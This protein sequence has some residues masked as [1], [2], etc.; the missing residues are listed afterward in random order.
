MSRP[1]T[2]ENTKWGSNKGGGVEKGDGANRTIY[3]PAGRQL[4]MLKV[5]QGWVEG[6][7]SR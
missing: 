4:S 1:C 7:I 2:W 6:S 3:G 5:K